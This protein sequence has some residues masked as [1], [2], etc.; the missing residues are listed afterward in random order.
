MALE[1]TLW[2]AVRAVDP[3]LYAAWKAGH[4]AGN[5][6]GMD[7]AVARQLAIYTQ[8]AADTM[9]MVNTVMLNSSM[10]AYRQ[11]IANTQSIERRMANNQLILNRRTGEVI[12]GVSTRQQ[13]VRR[14]IQDMNRDGLTGFIDRAGHQWSP[15]AYVSMD[16]R[17]TCHNAATQ[18]VFNRSDEYGCSLVEVSSHAAARPLCEPYQGR[19]YDRNN[20][21][22]TVTDLHGKAVHYEPWS[23]TSY[24]EPAGLLGINCGHFIYPFVPGYS[25]QRHMPT[26]NKKQ[27]EREY[28]ESQQQRAIERKIRQHKRGAALLAAAG[29]EAGAEKE[30]AKVKTAQALMRSFCEQTGR[31]R[32]RDREQVYGK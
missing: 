21:S 28:E 25:V 22:G 14:A 30:R 11:V 6:G 3:D 17:T 2:K 19:I 29:D 12:T 20:T 27:N 7:E 18:A 15:E 23:S 26:A 4:L 24:G 13:A 9:N 5:P 32:R 1:K 16:I 8:Q 10:D 31:T